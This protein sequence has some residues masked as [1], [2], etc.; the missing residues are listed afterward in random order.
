MK[1]LI[2]DDEPLARSELRYLLQNNSMVEEVKEADGVESAQD[3]VQTANPDVVFLDIQLD[4]GNGMVLAKLWKKLPQ[5]PYIVFATAYD[6]YALDTFDAEAIDYVLKPFDQIRID[7]TLIRINRLIG[8]RGKAESDEKK[9][10]NPRLSVTNE[11]RTM[12]I[13]KQNILYLEAKSG[14]VSIHTRQGSKIK[15]KETL[16]SIISQLDPNHFLR[17]HRSFVVNLNSVLELQPSFNHTYELTLNDNSK[18]AVS[19]SY[20]NVTKKALGII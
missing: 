3:M 2:V 1:I 20:V 8:K 14:I 4:D 6:Q 18:I 12:V 19:R 5:H 15:S 16:T 11:E 13:Q 9:Y 7:Q 10:D 17:V